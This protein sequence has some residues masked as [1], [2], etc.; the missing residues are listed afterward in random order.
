MEQ[1]YWI[2]TG[3]ACFG[4]QSVNNR[5]IRAAPIAKW[6]VGKATDYV[7]NYYK[8]KKNAIIEIVQDS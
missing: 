2:D 1:W 3:Y 7:L 6:S 8:T 5:I 4:I